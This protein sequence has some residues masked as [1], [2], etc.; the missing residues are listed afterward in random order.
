MASSFFP[1][2]L[3][4][5]LLPILPISGCTVDRL[6]PPAEIGSG[7]SEDRQLV[8]R[9]DGSKEYIGRVGEPAAYAAPAE[10]RNAGSDGIDYLNTPNL[11]GTGPDAVVDEQPV[12]PM[13]AQEEPIVS[14]E[15][16]AAAPAGGDYA[17]PSEGVS[18]DA[19]L[20]VVPGGAGP[21]IVPE[22]QPVAPGDM[23]IAEGTTDQPVVDG[24][25]TDNPTP[26][27]SAPAE[28]E[29]PEPAYT[30]SVGKK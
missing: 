3:A 25:G 19:E 27:L 17:I 10:P 8:G 14:A 22:A 30:G 23:T 7:P 12:E 9:V 15:D 16:V 21:V 28:E 5:L 2:R 11:A 20:G 18:M 24:I 6:V 29:I 1:P 13:S 4:A 26:Y